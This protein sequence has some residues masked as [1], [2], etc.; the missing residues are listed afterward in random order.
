MRIL[1]CTHK[2][3]DG[4]AERVVSLWMKGFSLQGN[5]VS[6]VICTENDQRDYSLPEETPVYNIFPSHKKRISAFV[7]RIRKLRE[8]IKNENPDIVITALGPWGLWAYLAS[9]GLKKIVINTEHNAFERPSTAPM[10]KGMFFYKF[11]VNKLFKAITVLT[12]ADKEY[13]GDRLDNVN[14]LPNPLAFNPA[15][16]LPS[17]QKIVLAAG[18]LDA[19]HVKGFDNLM[20]SW[21]IVSP[22]HPDWKL[23]VAGSG[24]QE[25]LSFLQGLLSDHAHEKVEFV[26]FVNDIINLYRQSSIF[27]LSSRYEG[28]GM[29][30]IEAMS[31]GCACIS[32]DYH[33]RQ[34]EIIL[35]EGF[36]LLCAPD[37]YIQIAQNLSVMME[38]EVLRK[39]VQM[40]SVERSKDYLLERIMEKWNQIIDNIK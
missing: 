37:D 35:D 39:K 12:Q 19:W 10:T 21:N 32:T 14:V 22:K 7:Y 2:L 6:L 9:L 13:I 17:K 15:T 40:A 30:L 5:Q 20:K 28:F 38:N 26:G 27:V 24:S 25:S 33:G 36:G 34:R 11:W 31:Q 3:N 1:F 23:I 16:S 29:V 18:R 4:G 8:I